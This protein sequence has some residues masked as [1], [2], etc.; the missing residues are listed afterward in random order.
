MEKFSRN[1]NFPSKMLKIL[2]FW[3]V[4]LSLGLIFFQTF[5]S[6]WKVVGRF[7]RF[8]G[9]TDITICRSVMEKKNRPRLNPTRKIVIP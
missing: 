8:F 7:G 3:L 1:D 4:G 6:V 5:G 9:L 2:T